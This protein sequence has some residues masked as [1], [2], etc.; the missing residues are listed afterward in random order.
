MSKLRIERPH[1]FAGEALL[2][3]DFRCEQQYQMD[4]LAARNASLYLHGISQGLEVSYSTMS[5]G[6][7][8]PQL[9]VTPG[10]AIDALGRQIILVEPAI[11]A[12][13]ELE[14]GVNYF[15]TINYHEVYADLSDASGT[16]GYKRIVQQ[17]QIQCLRNL[18]QHGLFIMLAAITLTKQRNIDNLHYR[19]GRNERRYVGSSVGSVNFITEGAGVGADLPTAPTNAVSTRLLTDYASISA[20]R[21]GGEGSD[22][23]LQFDAPLGRFTGSLT[24]R[25]NVGIG[26][27]QPLANLQVDA[28]TFKGKGT[29][30]W[31]GQK[32][33]FTDPPMPFLQSGDQLI[34]TTPLGYKTVAAGTVK[35]SDPSAG[36]V[37]MDKGFIPGTIAE[38]DGWGYTYKRSTLAR[39]TQGS[40]SGSVFQVNLDGSVGL[41]VQAPVGGELGRNALTIDANGN[42]GIGLDADPPSAALD[43]R[44]QIRADS[45]VVSDSIKARSFE[46][47]GSKLQGLAKFSF[48]TKELPGSEISNLYYERGKVGVLDTNPRASLSVGGGSAFIGSGVITSVS[49]T[50]VP[51]TTVVGYNTRFVDQIN[52]G[53]L[54]TIGT[55]NEQ[56]ATLAAT[57]LS[58]TTLTLLTPFDI[59]VV[60][61]PYNYRSAGSNVEMTGAGTI[62]SNGTAITGVGSSFTDMT[63]GAVLVI[64]RFTPNAMIEQAQ[65][66]AQVTS[67]TELTLMGEFTGTVSKLPFR[68]LTATGALGDGA[69]TISIDPANL[70]I[71]K[72]NGTTFFSAFTNAPQ[73][74]GAVLLTCPVT[75]STMQSVRVKSIQNQTQLT[76]LSPLPTLPNFA[77]SSAYMISSGLLGKFKANDAN[78][79]A[80]SDTKTML[81]P[82]MLL[83]YNAG[84]DNPNTVAINVEQDAVDPQYALQVNGSVSFNG[85]L[86]TNPVQPPAM[87][88]AYNVGA[89]NAN[90]VAINV[91]ADAF[92][93]QYALQVSG[94][95]SFDGTIDMLDL[96]VD[97]MLATRS[98]A[99]GGTTFGS[100]E[101]LLSVTSPTA[102]APDLLLV[103]PTNVQLG[104]V[105]GIGGATL[106]VSG[107]IAVSGDLQAATLSGIGGTVLDVTG[108]VTV[109][110]NLQAETL[111]GIAGA[112]LDVNGDLTVAG[113]LEAATLS[114]IGGASLAVN[115]NMEVTT[116]S[117]GSG[118]VDSHS[119]LFSVVPSNLVSESEPI[120][121][122]TSLG[123]SIGP[124]PSLDGLVLTVNGDVAASGNVQAAT[125][126]GNIIGL[127]SPLVLTND[128]YTDT[129][130]TDG[131]VIATPWLDALADGGG[132]P[133]VLTGT[134]KNSEG[135]QTSIL[136]VSAGYAMVDFGDRNIAPFPII[137][138]LI[139]PV[140]SGETWEL[141]FASC[142]PAV[143]SQGAEA[144][145]SW[146]PIG[147]PP[148]SPSII[149]LEPGPVIPP[150]T[151]IKAAI[152]VRTAFQNPPAASPEENVPP[153]SPSE[154]T[155]GSESSA[156]PPT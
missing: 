86:K 19:S 96:T 36:Q 31:N 51:S 154:A 106:K 89:G 149:P 68:Y 81:P 34:P 121:T 44:G 21:E 143:N 53:D 38:K 16:A 79:I 27:D 72:G 146:V 14:T 22:Y 29:I 144:P 125:L 124:A 26:T 122:V 9:E 42:V 65:C 94:P 25:H 62:S 123:V 104:Q 91:E 15:I 82:A 67:D 74:V 35:T 30:S 148:T 77:A 6:E 93:P 116:L 151:M 97:S 40:A 110:G 39:F 111:S 63:V 57:P 20:R 80:S 145:F 138:T 83:V 130:T 135:V 52:P 99:V 112:A 64:P 1:Y 133:G 28:V 88:V 13:A 45:L 11:V 18:D 139:M 92:D 50:W 24:I 117:V 46:G 101:V 12:L 113:K 48:W 23:F 49:S 60:D 155:S 131:L 141:T 59:P 127:P 100:D 109:K 55:L 56:Q 119:T 8:A 41:G 137:S 107:D 136:Q 75:A 114:G 5:N 87:L 43:V 153:A 142:G 69:G 3:E 73:L 7:S 37:S 102:A 156:T 2:T 71:V 132:F 108:D 33:S 47:N 129:A 78:G 84:A 118:N 76:L 115:G 98:I 120:L 147:A 32:V 10:M 85:L 140:R 17:P 61:S 66:V 134:T 58:D 128:F 4:M 70:T 126:T 90:T 103:S 54:I 150:E 152:A 95:V 105:A